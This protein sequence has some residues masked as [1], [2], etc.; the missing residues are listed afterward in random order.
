M[1]AVI[2]FHRRGR[3]SWLAACLLAASA[4]LLSACGGGSDLPAATAPQALSATAALGKKIF[5]DTSLS[6]SGALACGSCHVPSRAHSGD[7]GLAV[8]LG[9]VDQI[10]P[11]FRNAPSLRYLNLTPAFFFDSEG[12]PTGGFDRDGRADTFA[13]QSRRPL[14]AAHEMA[15]GDAATFAAKLQRASYVAD[16]TAIYGAGIF[17]DSDAAL[18]RAT[19]AV[20]VYEQEDSGF[21]PYSSKFDDFLRG[22]QP[23]GEQELRGYALYN[24]PLKGNCAGCHPSSVVAGALPLFTDFTY[25]NLGVPRNAEIP[26]NADASYYDLGLCGPDRTDLVATHQ[27]LCGAFKVPTLRNIALTAPYFHN[28]R[29][30]TLKEALQFYVQ[31]DTNPEKWYPSTAAGVQKFDDLPAEYQRN[32]NTTE[33]PYNRKLGDQP[34]LSD[35]EIDD[36]IAFLNT[37]TDA[38]LS[39]AD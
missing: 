16:F 37:L 32:V 26:A 38:D 28:G 5:F 10:T 22:S 13:A 27:D 34:A 23:L 12:T 20:Q 29:F 1:K 33:V 25:D 2:V 11:G 36:L 31:R 18:D 8:P 14:L 19:Q 24:N 6:A 9:G 30:A 17:D 39:P 35:A 15:N 7:D 3:S 4:F 21:H